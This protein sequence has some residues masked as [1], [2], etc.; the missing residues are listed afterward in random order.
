[1]L[2][3][4]WVPYYG[5]TVPSLSY[6]PNIRIIILNCLCSLAVCITCCRSILSIYSSSLASHSLLK[7]WSLKKPFSFPSFLPGGSVLRWLVGPLPSLSAYPL[8]FLSLNYHKHLTIFLYLEMCLLSVLFYHTLSY[9]PFS[10]PQYSYLSLFLD[11]FLATA[12]ECPY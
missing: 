4:W 1:M 9:F 2:L 3:I 8:T 7:L 10:N 12:L 11:L 6:Q 5:N